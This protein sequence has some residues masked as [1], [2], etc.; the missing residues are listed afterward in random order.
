MSI[1]SDALKKA[2]GNPERRR[3]RGMSRPP[4]RGVNWSFLLVI[5]VLVFVAAPV[6]VPAVFKTMHKRAPQERGVL[7]LASEPLEEKKEARHAV[8][9]EAQFVIEE[10]PIFG[11]SEE[12]A[13]KLEGIVVS[14][15]AQYAVLNGTVVIPGE[16]IDGAR[17]VSIAPD[18]VEL[19][20]QGRKIVL[21]TGPAPSAPTEE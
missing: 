10:R 3:D 20:Y 11:M 4:R 16:V 8:P 18:R 15:E 9:A 13:F 6:T 19:D 14:Q 2:G 17:L 1:I 7:T 21:K 5:A 12:P